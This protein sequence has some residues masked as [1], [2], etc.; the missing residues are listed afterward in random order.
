MYGSTSLVAWWS[1]LTTNHEIPGSIPGSLAGED[2]HDDHGLS[3]L[4]NL[5]L[6]PLLVLHAHTYHNH[7]HHRGNVTAPYGRPNLRSR[8]HFGH[9]Q[10]GGPLSL[11]GHVAALRGRGQINCMGVLWTYSRSR[12]H[13]Q[14]KYRRLYGVMYS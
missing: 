8:L 6:R 7:S 14:R 2:P 3:S 5:G 11:Y 13:S 9:N 12:N 10:E 4:Y 1:E